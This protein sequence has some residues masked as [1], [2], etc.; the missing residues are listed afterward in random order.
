MKTWE[1]VKELTENPDYSKVYKTKDF[2]GRPMIACLAKS[3]EGGTDVII[4]EDCDGEITELP[5]NDFM[6]NREWEEA[7]RPIRFV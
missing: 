4:A 5:M 3:Y 7:R 1:M 2:Y 6:R